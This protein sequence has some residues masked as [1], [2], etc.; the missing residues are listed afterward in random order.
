MP[1]LTAG[2]LIAAHRRAAGYSSRA[3][4][5]RAIGATE[6][7]VRSIESGDRSPTV[8]EAV[9]ICDVCPGLTVA[10]I[11]AAERARVTA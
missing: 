9:S 11:E 1:S 8:A 3:D 4:L 2:Q 7:I 6:K 5:A 10:M